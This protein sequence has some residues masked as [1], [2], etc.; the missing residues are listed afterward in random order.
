[1]DGPYTRSP[2]VTFPDQE[3]I[4]GP[5]EICG[6]YSPALAIERCSML[7]DAFRAGRTME[8]DRIMA[9]V[10]VLIQRVFDQQWSEFKD[11]P[12]VIALRD[13]LSKE[14]INK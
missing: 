12:E 13:R 4:Q 11:H 1:M 10:G 9:E 6:A 14:N 2:S 8:V 7:N 5:T 3:N